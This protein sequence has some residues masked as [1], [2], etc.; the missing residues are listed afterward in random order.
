MPSYLPHKEFS[1]VAPPRSMFWMKFRNTVAGLS[2]VFAGGF[3]YAALHWVGDHP[4]PLRDGYM[5]TRSLPDNPT[6]WKVGLLLA[7]ICL[8]AAGFVF[9]YRKSKIGAKS[10]EQIARLQIGEDHLEL[11]PLEGGETQ[12]FPF[13]QISRIDLFMSRGVASMLNQNKEVFENILSIRMMIR[14]SGQMPIN[15]CVMNQEMDKEN[16][17]ALYHEL[18]GIKRKVPGMYQRIQFWHKF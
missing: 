7:L 3:L 6:A 18:Q 16:L 17:G 15:I 12:R 5:F 8:L 14:V 2:L 10:F 1:V 9:G 11:I 13:Q 4:L